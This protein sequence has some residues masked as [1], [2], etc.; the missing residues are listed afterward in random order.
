MDMIHSRL[1]NSVLIYCLVLGTWGL[2]RFF[3]KQGVNSNFWG[4]AVIAE[5]LVL[6]QG[7]L[8]IVLWAMSLRPGRGAIHILYGVVSALSL[9]AVY[10]Y[11]RGRDER[12]EMLIY[13]VVLLF[14]VGIAI[15]AMATGVP[16]GE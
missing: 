12:R 6:V 10:V 16:V 13:A 3:R 15:R 14:M 11:T 9:P 7:G 4:A 2:W 5:I 8:G 1:A